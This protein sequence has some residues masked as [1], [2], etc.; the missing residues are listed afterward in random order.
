MCE[1]VEDQSVG[2][3]E[4][5]GLGGLKGHSVQFY[6]SEFALASRVVAYVLEGIRAGEPVLLFCTEAHRQMFAGELLAAGLDLEQAVATNLY[7]V[8]RADIVLEF[9]MSEGLPNPAQLEELVKAGLKTAGVLP[10]Q[11]LRLYSDLTTV[12][13]E[14]GRSQAG[15]ALEK[16][17]EQ[18]RRDYPFRLYCGCPFSAL[19]QDSPAA[20]EEL[21]E[22]HQHLVP[23]ESYESPAP[24][25]LRL[26]AKLQHASRSLGRMLERRS[27]ALVESEQRYRRLFEESNNGLY[28]L[29]TDLRMHSA[30]TALAQ[31]C[32]YE[33]RVALHEALRLVEVPHY[34]DPVKRDELLLSALSS[35]GERVSAE[36]E[37]LRAD[38]ERIWVEEKVVAVPKFRGSRW[39]SDS[40][41]IGF[42]DLIEGFEGSMERLPSPRHPQHWARC[43][44]NQKEAAALQG[45]PHR[46]VM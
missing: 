33:D 38:G 18:L 8:E 35:P 5:R 21:S 15:I 45:T 42:E 14:S 12:L 36:L 13:W 31:I 1:L 37:I 23:G 39:E 30:N 24:E 4:G 16:I 26:V 25:R 29:G 6:E 32:G 27:R 19:D 34:V 43:G 46:W 3:S 28:Q 44:P 7:R 20:F 41:G 22:L 2:S 10:S 9:I 17:W 40:K 11:H